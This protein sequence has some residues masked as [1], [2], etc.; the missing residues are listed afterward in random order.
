[1]TSAQEI[2]RSRAI[3]KLALDFMDRHGIATTPDNYALWYM[4][5]MGRNLQLV[6]EVD[7]LIARGEPLRGWVLED[8]RHRYTN[9]GASVELL[10]DTGAKVEEEMSR[11]VGIL[12]EAGRDAAAYGKVLTTA[13]GGL[14]AQKSNAEEII[15]TLL[16][17]TREMQSKNRA[18]ET[19]LKSSTH[20]VANLRE[21]LANARREAL[22]DALTGLPNRKAF[23]EKLDHWM[24]K[25]A[26]E[27]MPLCVLFGD[28]DRFKKFND[29][30]GHQL[31]DQVLK[32]VA[33]CIIDNL[34]NNGFGARYG[35]E[36]FA[37]LLPQVNLD[38]AVVV[39]NKIRKAVE[40]KK[41]VKRQTGEHLSR[42]TLS[43][44]C[45]V[46]AP[47]ETLRELIDR[48]DKALYAAKNN[49]RNQVRTEA[50]LPPGASAD[51]DL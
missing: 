24:A 28:V 12:S 15:G 4:H 38:A 35:G 31:G 40:L 27:R 22:T 30:F 37:I 44:G 23:D 3:A 33:Q 43:I 36:E 11:V 26:K 9:N 20:E 19:S 13:S 51:A 18:L 45:A 25:A 1:M 50:D 46:Q 39:A 16:R 32:L 47:G 17:S 5:A 29:D 7:D 42:V 41:I 21:N 6:H 8:L 48:A 14:G 49:G 34:P 10:R 2:E